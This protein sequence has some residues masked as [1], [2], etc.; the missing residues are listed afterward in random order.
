MRRRTLGLAVLATA[1]TGLGIGAGVQAQEGEAPAPAHAAKAAVAQDTSTRVAHRRSGRSHRA[2][3]GTMVARLVLGSLAHRLGVER[4]ALERVA[5]DIARVEAER[6]ARAAGLT[7]AQRAALRTCHTDRT[8]CDRIAARAAVRRLHAAGPP[9]LAALKE[10]V[11]ARAAEA[12][13]VPVETLLTAARAELEQRLGQAAALGF[14]S[15]RT[16]ELA[17]ACFDSPASCDLAALKASVPGRG[18]RVRPKG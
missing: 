9:D 14:A 11:A 10:R 18:S 13:G 16:R 15:P 8:R 17:L 3:H 12:L 2:G 6:F 1:A 4:E 5:H 7:S